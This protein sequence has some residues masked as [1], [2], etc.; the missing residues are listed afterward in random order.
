MMVPSYWVALMLGTVSIL[1]L[2]ATVAYQL[3]HRPGM[4]VTFAGYIIANLGLIWDALE[5]S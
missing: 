3:G 2:I 1:Y 5:K 4:A